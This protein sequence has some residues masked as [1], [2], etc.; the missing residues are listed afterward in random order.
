MNIVDAI[1]CQARHQP[2]ALAFCAPGT[3]FD[4]ISYGRLAAMTATIG[5]RAGAAGL[6]RGDTIAVWA[7]DPIFHWA[8]ILGL[9]SIG[10][11][12]L[13][14]ISPALPAEATVAAIVTDGSG[15]FLDIVPQPRIIHADQA[16]LVAASG[17]GQRPTDVEPDHD[18]GAAIARIVLTSGTTGGP[19]AVA[20]SHDMIV[21]RL[22][23]YDIA[24]G[25]RIP[26]C[27]RTFVDVG[28][29]AN[30]GYLWPL[31]VLA[32]GG[33]VF[34]RGSDPAEM[35]QALSLYQVQCMI[36]SPAGTAEFL[37]YYERSP[38]F[39]SPLEA[40]MTVGSML[41]PA[42]AAR[43]RAAMCS[44]LVS[45]Y[46]ATEASPVAAAPAHHVAGIPGAVGYV[47]PGMTVQA[48]DAADNALAAGQEG[49]IRVRGRVCVD[50][51][52]G[53]PP[54]A[55]TIFRGGWFYPGDVGRVT[56]DG[57]LVISGRESAVIHL[58]GDKVNPEPIE[59]ALLSCPGVVH[60]FAFG[61]PNALGIEE[62]WAAYT[63]PAELGDDTLRAHCTR[64]LPATLVP[65]RFVRLA[66]MP[67]NAA[68][69]IDRQ[70]AAKLS[71]LR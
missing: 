53:N 67:R 9:T 17:A 62:I 15:T 57:L 54:G 38:A 5:A 33:A 42:L 32:R 46:G 23:A 24:F 8:L 50:G 13:S 43:V 26:A 10:A 2:T 1:L 71:A 60:A 16:W 36:A 61:H 31:Y 47:A 40:M 69:K 35:L 39:A 56:R 14:L 44:H 29:T 49:L 51:Y 25:N 11:T 12:T 3:P 58:G 30:I 6:K 37:D 52:M 63:G 65:V 20:L 19:K 22:Q 27:T 70:A 34:L 21:R 18:G 41:A 55:E 59:A 45:G 66:D 64:R 7:K 28:V 48:A 68:G 4:R